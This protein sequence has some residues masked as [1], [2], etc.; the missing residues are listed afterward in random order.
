MTVSVE[1]FNT[2]FPMLTIYPFAP[3]RIAFPILRRLEAANWMPVSED[4]YKFDLCSDVTSPGVEIQTILEEM[5]AFVSSDGLLRPLGVN[6]VNEFQVSVQRFVPGHTIAVHTDRD[7]HATR[8][9]VNLNRSW[10]AQDGGVWILSADSDLKGN[11][12]LVPPVHNAA[13]AFTTGPN[14]F[15]ALSQRHQGI[16]YAVVFSFVLNEA[17]G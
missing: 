2:P 11:R 16:G 1:F 13:F 15:H 9:I 7:E 4:F 5:A 6:H 17:R 12:R 14:S 8:L 10:W 3:D